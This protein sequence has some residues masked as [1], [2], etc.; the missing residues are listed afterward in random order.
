M[1]VSDGHLF[2]VEACHY[3]DYVFDCL[4]NTNLELII[5]HSL[6]FFFPTCVAEALCAQPLGRKAELRIQFSWT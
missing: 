3:F 2:C 5:P 1:L 4:S 6:T